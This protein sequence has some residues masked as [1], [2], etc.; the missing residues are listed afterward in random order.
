MQVATTAQH[1][2]MTEEHHPVHTPISRLELRVAYP[3][4]GRDNP[5]LAILV[6]G[7][8]LSQL[9]GS[10]LRFGGFPP[11]YMLGE[12]VPQPS[13]SGTWVDSKVVDLSPLIQGTSARRVA[14]YLC[15]CGIAGCGVIAP[16]V[17][18]D[19][20][21][22]TW[23]DF[24]DYTGVFERPDDPVGDAEGRELPIPQIR[25]DARQYVAE[26][27][28]AIADRTW[29][30][31]SRAT[32]RILRA[33]L[34]EHDELIRGGDRQLGWVSHAWW[35]EGVGRFEIELRGTR[36]KASDRY[37][38]FIVAMTAKFGTPTSRARSIV[39]RLLTV[40]V[41]EWHLRFP[42]RRL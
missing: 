33:M 13:E 21:I 25:F 1:H 10:Q 4:D 18:T 22:V 17:A 15:S 35:H 16:V 36:V 41:S 19:G 30:S 39:D 3:G 14:L 38:Q 34:A 2:A 37:Q 26:V 40:P 12:P 11:D 9:P 24:R 32:A 28:R 23:S 7:T 42:S 8:E 5:A 6:D 31:Q 20:D 27:E 29:E